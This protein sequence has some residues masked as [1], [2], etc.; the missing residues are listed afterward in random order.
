MCTRAEIAIALG[1]P[2]VHTPTAAA[3]HGVSPEVDTLYCI[4]MIIFRQVL[5]CFQ[6]H[7]QTNKQNLS[8]FTNVIYTG[9]WCF[10]KILEDCSYMR[11]LMLHQ[12][13]NAFTF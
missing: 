12:D 13:P 1:P 7:K 4:E 9:A 11:S 8:L 6:I 10:C 5:P 3:H 2:I